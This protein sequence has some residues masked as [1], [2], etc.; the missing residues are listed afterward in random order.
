MDGSKSNHRDKVLRNAVRG[1]G[2]RLCHP[3]GQSPPQRGA[4]W[5]PFAKRYILGEEIFL[6]FVKKKSDKKKKKEI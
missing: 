2:I 4:V 1:P 6:L 5:I 3:P